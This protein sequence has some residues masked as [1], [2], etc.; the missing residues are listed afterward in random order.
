MPSLLI[1]T[2]RFPAS[3]FGTRSCGSLCFHSSGWRPGCCYGWSQSGSG[4]HTQPAAR[5]SC[6]NPAKLAWSPRISTA[7]C[8][9]SLIKQYLSRAAVIRLSGGL[10]ASYNRVSC[11]DRLGTF[12]LMGTEC[13]CSACT[14]TVALFQA[15]HFMLTGLVHGQPATFPSHLIFQAE[16]V[17]HHSRLHKTIL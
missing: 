17:Q 8:R 1:R 9:S 2:L 13:S 16:F 11:D 12:V 4:A 5:F 6:V 15:G 3:C 7:W 10:Q 14:H